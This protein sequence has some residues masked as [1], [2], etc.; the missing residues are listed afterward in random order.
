MSEGLEIALAAIAEVDADGAEALVQRERSGLARFAASRVNQPT[1]IENESVQLRVI[2]DR[3]VGSASTNRTD[4]EGLR[5]LARRAEEAAASAPPD[6]GFP[7]LAPAA[8]A[9]AVA[10]FDAE[11]ASLTPADQARLAWAAIDAAGTIDLFGLFTSGESEIA[12]ASTTGLRV[13]QTMTDASLHAIAA[14]EHESGYAAACSWRAVDLDPAAVAAEAVETARRTANAAGVE[15]GRLRAVLEPYAVADLLDAFAYSSLT[16]LALLEER[17]YLAGRIGKPVFHES[18]TILDDGR[19]PAGLPKAFDFEGVP[20]EP[21]T[22]VEKGVPLDVVWDRRT[23]LR[24]GNGRHSTGHALPGPAQRYGPMPMNLVLRPGATSR[25]E[26]VE[27][28]SDGIFV[29]RLHYL[30]VVD[31]REGIITGMTRDGTFRI[32][33]GRIRGPVVNLRFTTSFPELL[34]DLLGIGSEPALVSTSDFYDERY[35]TASLVPSLATASFRVT[36][37]GGGPGL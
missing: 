21:V 19:D 15:P 6:P 12:V 30:S 26:L 27:A 23:A 5:A 2:R 8:T 31:E 25:D 9:P 16:A 36:G 34:R 14:S 1:L 22:L 32:E 20:K 24:G 13:S 18:L 37:L 33:G 28:V 7:G 3:R 11:T 17:S 10:G 29:T 35:A 4:A